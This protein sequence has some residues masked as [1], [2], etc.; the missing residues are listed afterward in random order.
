MNQTLQGL[1]DPT[2]RQI[3]NHLRLGE[4]A[5]GDIERALGLSQPTASKQLRTLREA[6]LVAVRKQA[7]RR[8]Y[9]LNPAPLAALDAWLEPYRSFWATKPNAL[10]THLNQQA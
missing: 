5:A 9:C 1:A 4:A 10:E 8:L 6:G 2:R 7:Q 3:I